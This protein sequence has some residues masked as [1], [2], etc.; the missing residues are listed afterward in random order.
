[1]S[2]FGSLYTAVSGLNAQSTA[3]GNISDNVANSQ[4]VGYKQVD[5]SFA[6][7]LTQSTEKSNSP[8]SV[9]A[10]S[11]FENSLQ[12]T[13]TGTNNGLNLAI[14][15]NGFF[16]VNT[17]NG[18]S[19]T[20]VPTLSTN[21]YYTRAGDFSADSNGYLVNSEGD[22]LDGWTVD[23]T[24][25]AAT[26]NTL[27]PIQI[28]QAPNPPTATTTVALS[29][30]LPATPSATSALAS[31]VDVYDS[32]GNQEALSMSY[33]QSTA[34]PN[35]W[36]MTVSQNG[37]AIGT[38]DLTFGA[39]GT[40]STLGNATGG[41]TLPGAVSGTGSAASV[42]FTPTTGSFAAPIT[43]G[44]GNFGSSAGVTQFAGTNLQLNSLT[45]NGL[46]SGAYAGASIN[47]SGQV[48]AS[49]ANGNTAVVAQVPLA[50]FANEDGLVR[51]NAQ[52]FAV[53]PQSG[54]ATVQAEGSGGAGSFVTSSVESSNVDISGQLT[55]LIVAQQA[56]SANTKII[57]TADQLLQQTVSMVT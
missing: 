21:Q 27:A 36:T 3:F 8:G 10:S 41:L 16:A 20:G 48:V 12:G 24:T 1:M 56:Y 29:A 50:T 55:Q 47:A 54:A 40:L 37:T 2:L 49:Y 17:A 11:T 25:G 57:T 14:S 33:A 5:T 43:L 15:G 45:Q 34:A 9:I 32:H 31:N 26:S 53:T 4:T 51:Q 44:L 35:T 23:P 7:Y 13:V 38:A 22:Y 52:N 39:D 28:S 42:S 30:N 19:A 6:D 18:V 46:A